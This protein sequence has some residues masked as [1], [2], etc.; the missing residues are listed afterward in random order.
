MSETDE[1]EATF[2]SVGR[3]K[4]IDVLLLRHM[5][6]ARGLKGTLQILDE[7]A[8]AEEG[9]GA[10]EGDGWAIVAIKEIGEKIVES[11]ET[12]ILERFTLS[13]EKHP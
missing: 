10:L 7:A 8:R 11:K 6:A 4:T 13:D 3:F 9:R 5:L 12:P 2:D 1:H